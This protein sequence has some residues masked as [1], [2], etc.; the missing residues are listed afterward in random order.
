ME[1]NTNKSQAEIYREER[2]ERLAKAAAKNAKKSPKLSKAKKIA[3]KVIAIVLAVVVALGAIGGILNFFGTPEK[4]LKVS[5]AEKEYSFTLGEFNYYYFNVWSNFQS[6]AY[7]YEKYYGEGVGLKVTGYD[8]KKAPD[9]QEYTDDYAQVTGIKAEE[10]GVESPTWA[11]VFR[12]AAVN[13]MVQIQ[14]GAQK[15]EETKLTLTEEDTKEI[16]ETLDELTKNAK[17]NDY[18]LNRYLRAQFGNGVTEK[19]VRKALEQQAL[20]GSYFEKLKDDLTNAVTEDRVN[21]KYTENKDM[22]DVVSL[23]LYAFEA[24]E[25]KTEEGATEDAKKAAQE[26]ENKKAKANADNFIAAVTDEESFIKLADAAIK[27]DDPKSKVEAK[28]ATDC[29]DYT[30][31]DFSKDNEDLAK[32]VYDDARK[33]GDKTVIDAGDGVYFAVLMTV[34]PHQDTSVKNHDVRHI[35]VEFPKGEDGKTVELTDKIKAET[36]AKA[37]AILDEYLKNP[38][39]ENFAALATEKST[40]TGS[41]DNGGLYEDVTKE[42]QFVEPFLNWTTDPARKK[43]DTGLVETDY[44]YHVMFYSNGDGATWYEDI[45]EEIVT[46]DYNAVFDEVTEKYVATFKLNSAFL[47]YT[48]KREN[49][50]I[51]KIVVSNYNK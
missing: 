3:G 37:Q 24:D 11:D 47:N 23:R 49:K 51:A 32:W 13:Q 44:G 28:T 18:S 19:L 36:R 10:L 7:Q 15:A 45:K 48:V 20:A 14:Y 5:T 35:L 50:H 41:K 31:E 4:V 25:A 42:T 33:V 39:E 43:G 26:E 12:Y 16:N 27:S 29:A 30:Y 17:D 34:L 8:Y 38:T 9:A 21:A 2:K 46:D 1:N 22:Y 6:Q 40:D